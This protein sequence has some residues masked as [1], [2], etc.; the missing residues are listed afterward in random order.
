[1]HIGDVVL[2]LMAM[3]GFIALEEWWTKPRNTGWKIQA[4]CLVVFVIVS[5]AVPVLWQT[6]VALNNESAVDYNHIVADEILLIDDY[7][8]THPEP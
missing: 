3:I 5:M 4:S 7:Y 6:G 8:T 2:V 1:M